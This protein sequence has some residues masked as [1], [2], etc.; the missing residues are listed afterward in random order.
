VSFARIG[1]TGYTSVNPGVVL[2]RPEMRVID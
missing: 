1:A 2:E